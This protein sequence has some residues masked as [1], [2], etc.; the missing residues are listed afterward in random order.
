MGGAIERI[1]HGKGLLVQERVHEPAVPLRLAA[2]FRVYLP[3]SAPLLSG[4]HGVMPSPSSRAIG[5][6]S[7]S[8]VRSS[9]EY[10]IWS[11]MNVDDARCG[12]RL[13]C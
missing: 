5:T 7:C 11:P 12:E 4:D 8:M 10:S 1:D 9:S 2:F 3:L 13:P 6:S